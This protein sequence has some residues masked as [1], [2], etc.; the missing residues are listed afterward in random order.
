M[1]RQERPVD[2]ADGPLQALAHELRKL[3]VEAGN[4][5]YRTLARRTGYSASTLSE[6]ANGK[7]KPTLDVL[8]AYVGALNGDPDKWRERW[9][10]LGGGTG[11]TTPNPAEPEE[12]AASEERAAARETAAPY[13]RAEPREP[14]TAGERAAVREPAAPPGRA[15]PDAAAARGPAASEEQAEPQNNKPP[16]EGPAA[17]TKPA[18]ADGLGVGRRGW[19]WRSTRTTTVGGLA[20]VIA[21]A[22]T[23]GAMQWK[24]GDEPPA[25][26]SAHTG[27]PATA[28]NAVFYAR[29]YGSGTTIRRGPA[30]VEHPLATVPAGCTIGLTGFCAGEPIIDSTAYTPDV[31]WFMVAGGGVLASATVHGNPPPGMPLSRCSGDRPLPTAI[32]LHMTKGT[33]TAAGRNV[34]VVGYAAYYDGSWHQIGLTGPGD[35]DFATGWRPVKGTVAAAACL[36]GEGSIGVTDLRAYPAGGESRLAQAQRKAAGEVACL[37]P[38]AK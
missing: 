11:A 9:E 33:L 19:S 2:P 21:L 35:G 29:T 17:S 38:T 3:R 30:R 13:G 10:A 15:E 25:P 14:A 16:R 18:A 24:R 8:L 27:C 6:A 22:L 37:Y 20:V 31:R 28:K 12:Q 36:G 7:R 4:P 1:A 26:P 23:A 34:E 5:T 32:T